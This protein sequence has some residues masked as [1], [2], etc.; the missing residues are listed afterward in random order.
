MDVAEVNR[1]TNSLLVEKYCVQNIRVNVIEI[2]NNGRD[3]IP[4]HYDDN[5]VEYC[6][7]RRNGF[8]IE[9]AIIDNDYRYNISFHC[10]VREFGQPLLSNLLAEGIAGAIA[11][12]ITIRDCSYT[13][14]ALRLSAQQ[15]EVQPIDFVSNIALTNLAP[16]SLG[17]PSHKVVKTLE[18]SIPES[19]NELGERKLDL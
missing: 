10:W 3:N 6:L 2:K 11:N 19:F 18:S 8:T 7:G 5:R 12:Y 16:T 13:S 4:V 17:A 9:C 15:I 1:L 14:N